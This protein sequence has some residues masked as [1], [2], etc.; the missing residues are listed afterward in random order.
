M[1]D[2]Y[3]Y[4]SQQLVSRSRG[5]LVT[6]LPPVSSIGGLFVTI[7][8]QIILLHYL[9]KIDTSHEYPTQQII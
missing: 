8:I 5:S 1:Y 6:G 2:L 3:V 4:I 7:I 9:E